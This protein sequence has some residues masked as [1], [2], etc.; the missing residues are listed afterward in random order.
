MAQS[1]I[2]KAE[3]IQ[4]VSNPEERVVIEEFQFV[5]M[6]EVLNL[7]DDVKDSIEDLASGK[8]GEVNM[9][10]L[11]YELGKSYSALVRAYKLLDEV[12]DD[13]NPAFGMEDEH[14]DYENEN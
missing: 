4:E 13:L 14:T 8:F 2:K 11:S 7:I 6:V 3:P 5:K 1:A 9:F 12:T 10:K